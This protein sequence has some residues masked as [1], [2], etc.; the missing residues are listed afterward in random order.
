MRI[1][2]PVVAQGCLQL[3]GHLPAADPSIRVC[4]SFSCIYHDLGILFTSKQR[5]LWLHKLE[6][7][8]HD[9]AFEELGITPFVFRKRQNR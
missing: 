6:Q 7:A 8:L 9:S 5:D 3:K 2:L 4:S 1:N